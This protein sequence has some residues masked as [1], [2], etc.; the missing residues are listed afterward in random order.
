M[1]RGQKTG[2]VPNQIIKGLTPIRGARAILQRLIG[3]SRD[4]L[5]DNLQWRGIRHF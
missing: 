4:K 2:L 3:N 5:V 1:K